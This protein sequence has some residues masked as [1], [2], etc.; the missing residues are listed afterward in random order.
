MSALHDDFFTYFSM[1]RIMGILNITPDSFFDGGKYIDPGL[2]R[3]RALEMI[4]EGADVI[5]I[6]GE[7]SRP[8]S[9]PI[10]V[11]EEIQRVLPV[12]KAIRSASDIPLSIDTYKPEVAAAALAAGADIV[13]DITGLRLKEM[14]QVVAHAG[15]PAIVMHMQGTPPTMQQE[16]LYTNCVQEISEFFQQQINASQANGITKIILDPGIGFGKTTE[17]NLEILAGLK[18][19]R[20]FGLPIMVGCSRKRFIGALL[21]ADVHERLTG[22]LATN[23]IAIMNGATLIRVHDVRPH[24]EMLKIMEAVH[25]AEK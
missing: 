13:N 6:G 25:N 10:F 12:I 21:G 17:H 20:A 9:A 1:P 3:R 22:T 5:D 24:R 2:A 15:C 19:F 11:E 4:D 14:R 7:S 23:M 16:P 8:G 18:A